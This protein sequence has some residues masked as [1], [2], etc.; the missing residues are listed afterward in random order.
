MPSDCEKCI[1]TR[2]RKSMSRVMLREYSSEH[3]A[4]G[5][6]GH[7]KRVCTRGITNDGPAESE[8]H[9]QRAGRSA[10][11]RQ[12]RRIAELLLRELRHQHGAAVENHGE[13]CDR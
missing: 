5:T 11:A 4:A 9:R 13:G 6:G 2:C 12:Q 8:D 3:P 10:Q 1:I 7:E